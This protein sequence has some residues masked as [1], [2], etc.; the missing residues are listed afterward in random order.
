MPRRRPHLL[1]LL[2]LLQH[3][4]QGRQH[5]PHR[6]QARRKPP[7]PHGHL[8]SLKAVLGLTLARVLPAQLRRHQT[9]LP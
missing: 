3:Q 5:A 6:H 7:V 9:L 1:R 2:R 8:E 4:E